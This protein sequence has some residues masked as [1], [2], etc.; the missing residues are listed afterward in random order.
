MSTNHVDHH[1][2]EHYV[3]HFRESRRGLGGAGPNEWLAGFIGGFPGGYPLYGSFEQP[4]EGEPAIVQ[5]T[6]GD[7]YT[8]PY[9]VQ[10]IM[11]GVY[12]NCVDGKVLE[13]PPELE[14]VVLSGVSRIGNAMGLVRN[15]E[16]IFV[17]Q[18]SGEV[19]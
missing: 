14:V 15:D 10:E 7:G 6:D 19:P 17:V 5:F 4:A 13:V 3:E 8:W 2:V 12:L 16:G 18:V 1:H 11:P 9:L